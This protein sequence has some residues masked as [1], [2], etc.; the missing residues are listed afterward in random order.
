MRKILALFVILSVVSIAD[1]SEKRYFRFGD[2]PVEPERT[3]HPG[4]CVLVLSDDSPYPITVKGRKG[5][6]FFTDTAYVRSGEELV[7]SSTGV[8]LFVRKCGNE[9]L[10]P[11]NWT[12]FGRTLFC[13]SEPAPQYA[14]SRKHGDERVILIDHPAPPPARQEVRKKRRWPWILAGV[15]V[16]AVLVH[17]IDD[18]N[19]VVVLVDTDNSNCHGN[20]PG[21][22][23]N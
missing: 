18:G 15:V 11:A 2:N 21:N 23:K 16:G 10:R 3:L 13:Q 5:D 12:P 17:A 22:R 7:V 19:D 9:I 6:K 8:A 1:A 20:C 14:L 4:E